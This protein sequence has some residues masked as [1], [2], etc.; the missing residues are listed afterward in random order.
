MN[1]VSL[2]KKQ[3]KGLVALWNKHL[4]SE[5]PMTEELFK[6]NSFDDDNV[7]DKGSQVAVTDEGALIGF[8]VAKHWQEDLD[9]AMSATTGWIQVLLVDEDYRNQGIGSR[10]LAHAEKHLKAHGAEQ[11]LLGR[12]PYHYFPGIP[13]EYKQTAQWFEKI[14]Y[15]HEGTE[16]DLIGTYTDEDDKSKQVTQ[17]E[18]V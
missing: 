8:V 12:D 4:E 15:H 13:S 11:I 16:F 10:L 9:V 3:L 14:G 1:F 2:D 18:G 7:C 6:Q 5:F 17:I